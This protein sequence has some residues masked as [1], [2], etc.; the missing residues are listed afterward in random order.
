MSTRPNAKRVLI[1]EDEPN[2]VVSLEFLLTQA[3]YEVH[4][5]TSG[6]DALRAL[7]SVR[8]HLVLLDLM[9]PLVNGFDICRRL[10]ADPQLADTKVV[11]LTAKGRASEIEKGL[12]LGADAYVTKPFG[13]RELMA[14]VRAL[15]RP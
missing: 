11:V 12:A 8:P 7:Q 1:V 14:T 10:R 15:L 4:I 9:L 5:A 13:T 2:I 3:G 6:D